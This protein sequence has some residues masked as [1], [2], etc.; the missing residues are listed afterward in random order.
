[1]LK[2][3]FIKS[4]SNKQPALTVFDAHGVWPPLVDY[5]WVNASEVSA[6]AVNVSDALHRHQPVILC[7]DDGGQ[8]LQ[9]L[10]FAEEITRQLTS[11]LAGIPAHAVGQMILIYQPRWAQECWLPADGQR[12]VIA[13]RQIR[14]ILA[15]LYNHE[16]AHQV[17]LIYG[18]LVLE[19]AVPSV[20]EDI[21]VDGLLRAPLET[22]VSEVKK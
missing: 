20:I 4:Q 6:D 1:M 2:S 17:R 19:A 13:H 18:G 8:R 16:I 15:D 21:N 9:P 10:D 3:L 22:K 7:L 12:I 14:D 5:Y 11:C